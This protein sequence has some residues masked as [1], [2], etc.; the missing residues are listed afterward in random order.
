MSPISASWC[1]CTGLEGYACDSVGDGREALTRPRPSA[2]ICG[3]GRDDSRAGWARRAAPCAGAS[4]ATC[5]PDADRATRGV[6]QGGGPPERRGRLPHQAVCVRELVA[7]TRA[8][9]RRPA[10]AVEAATDGEMVTARRRDRSRPAP[11]AGPAPTSS[12]PIREF[13]LLHLL[14]THAGI[15]F[16]REG[17]AGEDLAG[18]YVRHRP[19]RGLRWRRWPPHRTRSR[20]SRFLL[21]VWGVGTN[22]RTSKTVF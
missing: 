11:R 22:S 19:E 20:E 4:T 1:P 21:T 17:A 7:R 10:G 18:R 6:R 15:V 2:S 5:D 14:A 3:P 12:S 16:S 9:L 13:H 8:L